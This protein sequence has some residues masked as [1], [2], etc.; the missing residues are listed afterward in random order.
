LLYEDRA[1]VACAVRQVDD[2]IASLLGHEHG[3]M[4]AARRDN[5]VLGEMRAL[6]DQKKSTR[7]EHTV[8]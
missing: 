7:S 2:R 3:E 8:H 6:F 4:G 5:A 1:D